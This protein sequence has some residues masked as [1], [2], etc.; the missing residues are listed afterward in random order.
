MAT[1]KSKT[2]NMKDVAALANVSVATVSRYLNGNLDRMSKATA[3]RIKDAINKLNYVPNSTARQMK[4]K[5]SKMIAVVVSNIDDFFSTELFKGISSMLESKGY[6]GV[7]FDSDSDPDREKAILRSIGSQMFDGLIIQP[8]NNPSEIQSSLRRTI[9]ITVVDR[10][11]DGSPWPQVV[12]DNYDISQKATKY[13]LKQGFKH[14]VV[15]TSDVNSA[16][17]RMERYRGIES[18]AESVEIVEVPEKSFNHADVSGRLR[19]ALADS[20]ANSLVFC[21]KERWL[22]EFIPNLVIEGV[23]DNVH[24]TAT[25]FADTDIAHRLEPKFKLISQNPFLMGADSAE[26][27]IDLIV[28]DEA[29][30]E[31]KLVVP[32]KF[33]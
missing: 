20:F 19:K 33:E 22:L 2:A 12:T 21:L 17:T 29:T 11:L 10:E 7:L 14:V 13:F 1:E 15:L 23:I 3:E 16:R 4:T 27:I 28:N 18:A 24:T 26:M 6:I 9:P 8:I 30:K 5:K 31:Q 32:A 25:A